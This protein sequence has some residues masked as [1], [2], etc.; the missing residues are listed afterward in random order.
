MVEIPSVVSS[1]RVCVCVWTHSFLPMEM[2]KMYTAKKI[3]GVCSSVGGQRHQIVPA[4][5]SAEEQQGGGSQHPGGHHPHL[6]THLT[7]RRH[8]A[9]HP[10]AP[11]EET[12]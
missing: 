2:E 7:Q 5:G 1:A 11:V 12:R 3:N 6:L 10:G 4:W 9:L 8:L